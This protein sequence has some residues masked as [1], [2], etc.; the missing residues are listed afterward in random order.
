[1]DSGDSRCAPDNGIV[2]GQFAE[3][4]SAE[5]LSKQRPPDPAE[6]AHGFE[7]LVAGSDDFKNYRAEFVAAAQSLIR[8]GQCD[9]SDFREWGGWM[10][11]SNHR[12]RPIYFIYCGGA[13]V[14]NRLYL[15][16]E[17]GEITFHN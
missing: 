14:S 3:W 7:A 15:D 9:E 12:S 11:S 17:T 13:T 1:V 10:R 2:E 4:A 8:S 5:L 16:V 6:G